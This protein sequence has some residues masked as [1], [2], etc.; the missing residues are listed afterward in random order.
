MRGSS[1]ET[2]WDKTSS[3]HHLI[4][5]VQ[6][7]SQQKKSS[8]A[9]A[10]CSCHVDTFICIYIG[11]PSGVFVCDCMRYYSSTH[12]QIS[13]CIQCTLLHT[14]ALRRVSLVCVGMRYIVV[15]RHIFRHEIYSS[16]RTLIFRYAILQV[17]SAPNICVLILLPSGVSA[18]VG[19]RYY[20]WT[21]H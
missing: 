15:C 14:T 7:T 6:K 19:M 5:G 12:H 1:W 16:M 4:F 10:S 9:A 20:S 18:C 21:Q 8:A 13:R 17:N 3:S 11:S 2:Q